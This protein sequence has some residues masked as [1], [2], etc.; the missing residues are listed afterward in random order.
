[1]ILWT[2]VAAL[3]VAD[4][5]LGVMLWR[6]HRR[7]ERLMDLVN[8]E[9]SPEFNEEPIRADLEDLRKD[10][11]TDL[12]EMA[13]RIKGLTVAVA[14]GIERVDRSE[15]R[16]GATIKRAQTKLALAGYEDPGVEAEVE[17]LRVLD[18]DGIETGEL[19]TV[20]SDVGSAGDRDSSV[21]GVTVAQLQKVRGL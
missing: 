15:R 8:T 17:G 14:E 18:G 19:P 7:R 6:G 1:M 4:A 13:V 12:E 2:L 11:L 21:P 10:T 3:F 9:P 20:P 5:V 16:I